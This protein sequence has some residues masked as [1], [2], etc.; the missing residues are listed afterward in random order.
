VGKRG[1]GRDALFQPRFLNRQLSL[2]VS[3]MS[4][5]W[6]RRSSIAVV[7]LASPKICGQYIA[8]AQQFQLGHGGENILAF[9]QAARRRLS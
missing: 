7:I 4:Q 1:D 6:V 3:T 9:H 5:W 8:H 2:P